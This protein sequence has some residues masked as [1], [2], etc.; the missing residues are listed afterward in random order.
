[1]KAPKIINQKTG[2]EAII[3]EDIIKF[4]RY[5]GWLVKSTHGN[6]YQ[7]GFPDLYCAHARYGTRWI[8]VKNAK[9]YS[10]TPAQLEFFP[11]LMA[12]GVGVWILVAA[13]E[14]EY[15][16]LWIE[17]NWHVYLSLLNPRSAYHL[18]AVVTE[19]AVI[20]PTIYKTKI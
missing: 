3:Q 11:L 20:K 17:P 7:H 4:L 13:T 12:H 8:E 5:R 2:P 15:Q 14:S 19:V 1:M 16:K 9:C 10:F 6:A 18:G